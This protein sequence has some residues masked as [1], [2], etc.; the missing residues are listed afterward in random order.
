MAI[1][2]TTPPIV[3][4]GLVLHLDAG[5][6]KS[7]AGS[8]TTWSDLSGQGKN[9]TLIASPTF[10]SANQ[11]YLTFN[12]TS[13][14]VTSS[15][16]VSLGTSYTIDIWCYPTNTLSTL[17]VGVAGNYHINLLNGLIYSYVGSLSFITPSP[18]ITANNWYNIVVTRATTTYSAYVNGRSQG[19]VTTT[20]STAFTI[21]GLMGSTGLFAA[22]NLA[23]VK[24]YNRVLTAT[25]VAQ[26]YN[27]LKSRF[28][29]T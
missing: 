14:Y 21:T 25:E 22:G 3:T 9:E 4:N 5:S 28:G 2:K 29:L 27:A 13:Q 17:W 19:S 7:Y 26:N 15:A 18:L 10:N 16:D 6:R 8:G 12:G 1:Y 20:W 11:G 23:Q 24:A